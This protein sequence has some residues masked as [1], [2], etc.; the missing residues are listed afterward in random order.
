MIYWHSKFI[1]TFF[2]I[3]IYRNDIQQ[4]L[5]RVF[6]EWAHSL[7]YSQAHS[8]VRATKKIFPYKKKTIKSLSSTLEEQKIES[9]HGTPFRKY[10]PFAPWYILNAALTF[11]LY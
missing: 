1:F 3:K 5:Y 4:Y 9:C 10:I 2:F 8:Q 6:Q 11:F 7:V